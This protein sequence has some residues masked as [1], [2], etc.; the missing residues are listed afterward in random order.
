MKLIG[1][2][3][4][5]SHKN[6]YSDYCYQ[7]D[8]HGNGEPCLNSFV[9]YTDIGEIKMVKDHKIVKVYINEDDS[10]IQNESKPN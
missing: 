9:L 2:A 3:L 1:Y 8:G 6:L 10:T 4:I 5:D 7:D